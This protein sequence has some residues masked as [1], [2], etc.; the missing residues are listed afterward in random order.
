MGPNNQA[1]LDLFRAD[2]DLRRAR[3]Q[4]D[5]ATR[6][7]RVQSKRAELAVKTHAELATKLKHSRA[8][9]M[10][11]DSDLKARDAR[12][13]HLREQQ[14]A[15]ENSKQFQ[16]FQ[17]EINTQKGEKT[18]LEDSA[19]AKLAD[20]E[21]LQKLEATQRQA[22]K[23]EQTKAEQLQQSI[24][25]KTKELEGHIQELEPRRDTA[26]EK[27]PAQ[28]V[29]MFDR[30]ADNYDGEA[31]A[32]VGHIEGKTEGYYC[33]GCNMEL[34]VD[35][36]NRL[37][38][39]DVIMNCPGCGRI[40]YVP[41]ELTP[42]MA[43]RQKKTAK[44]AAPRKKKAP[45]DK[46]LKKG[47]KAEKSKKIVSADIRRIITTA[48]AE[49]LRAAELSESTPIEA[50]VFVAGD[51]AGTY[52]VEAL[53]GFRRLLSGKMQAEDLEASVEVKQ[54]GEDSAVPTTPQEP[55]PMESEELV[56]A[57]AAGQ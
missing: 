19:V 34:V 40:L 50:E 10:E 2:T 44:K 3:S 21:E 39:R 36:Y 4:L 1:L 8:K 27:V 15:T 52:K 18:R 46:P 16:N 49:S 25:G 37:M 28:S 12:I 7:L 24:G 26:A 47:Q 9:Q 29:A 22:V 38:T 51:S 42:E 53:A 32:A 55:T 41:E 33:T 14:S 56:A 31:L 30:L 54:V 35:V 48:A 23:E 20:V 57:D 45:A 13:E 43:V 11:L 5:A 17:V 6:G